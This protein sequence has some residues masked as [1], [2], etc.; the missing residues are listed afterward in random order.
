MAE[1]DL[2]FG[3]KRKRIK[4]DKKMP[5]SCP[6]YKLTENMGNCELAE[7]CVNATYSLSENSANG[8]CFGGTKKSEVEHRKN[9]SEKYLKKGR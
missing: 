1:I 6:D 7:V 4:K 8:Y 9:Y 3:F 2:G 5:P